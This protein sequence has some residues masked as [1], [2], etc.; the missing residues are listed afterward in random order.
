M[1]ELYDAYDQQCQR[2]G[3]VDFAELLLRAYELLQRNQPLRQHYQM[4]FRHILVDEFQDTNDLQYN[5][6]KLLAGHGT[7]RRRDLRGGRRRPEHLRLPR[8]QRRQHA[9]LRARFRGQ[10]PDQA[11]AELPLARP[12]PRQRQLP[13]RQQR[14]RLGKNLRTDAGQ[15]EPVRIYE[16]RPTSKRR[17][18][19]S[20]K[21]RA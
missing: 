17:S 12:H 19:S 11:G 7:G 6:L 16:A 18:G 5:L 4:R 10:E 2:E 3:V 1:V 21:P 13:D 20:K 14:K 15:G 9:G 8:R